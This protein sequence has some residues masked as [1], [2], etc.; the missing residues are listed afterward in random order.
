MICLFCDWEG[1]DAIPKL[2]KHYGSLWILYHCP[3]CGAC[4][5]YMET[6][7][8]TVKRLVR[9]ECLPESLLEEAKKLTE[10]KS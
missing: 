9:L 2:E 3:K 8:E 5:G 10:V 6:D 1:Y 7:I 4:V